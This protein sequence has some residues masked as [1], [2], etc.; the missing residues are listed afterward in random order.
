MEIDAG[1][2][3]EIYQ[4]RPLDQALVSRISPGRAMEDIL[5]ESREIGYPIAE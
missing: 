5:G 2:V 4:H 3:A 1:A